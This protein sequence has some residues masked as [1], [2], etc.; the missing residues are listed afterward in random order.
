[1]RFSHL[2]I[3]KLVDLEKERFMAKGFHGFVWEVDLAS[4]KISRV[5]IPEEEY[6]KYF[7]GSG[8]AA[9]LLYQELD[10]EVDPLSERS[11][12]LVFPGLLT[13]HP[14]PTGCRTILAGRSPLTGIWGEATA[15][16]FWG[17]ELRSAGVDGLIIRGRAE[18]PTYLWITTEGVELRDATHLWGKDTFETHEIIRRETDQRARVTAIGIAGERLCRVAALIFEGPASR[19]AGRC[20][21]GALVGS[22]NLKA[23]AVRA[24]G[25]VPIHDSEGLRKLLKK[26]I[27]SIQ[28]FTAGLTKLGTPGAVEAVEAHGD[29]P[30]KNWRDGSWA[31]GA[32]ATC[33]QTNL[34]KYLDRHYACFSCPIRCSKIIRIE[35][36][37]YGSVHS[38][39][40]EYETVAGFGGN[41]L[42]DDFQLIAAANERCNRYGLDTISTSAAVAFAM[43]CYEKGLLSHQDTGGLDLKWGDPKAILGLVDWIA[44]GDGLGALL[45]QGTRRAAEQIGRNALEYVV[46]AKGLDLAFHD[47][48]AFTSMAANYATAV[49]G[50]CHLEGLTYFLGRGVPLEDMGYVEPP[51][52]HANEG[53]GKIAYDLQNYM[54]I[55]NP[56]GLCKF[57]FLGRVGPKMIAR[58]I[59]KVTGW[60]M[61]QTALLRTG[62]RIFNLKRMYNIRLGISRKDDMLPPR[63]MSHPR[64][65]GRAKG[66]LPHLGK[67]LNEY[68]E[69][70][71]WSEE[72]IPTPERL[73]GLGLKWTLE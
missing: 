65:D 16:G 17:A 19:A 5:D 68:Y 35:D 4:R 64:P 40:P 70:R 18:N 72:G 44:R 54:G 36:G 38:H 66:V 10:P 7:A 55:Y 14:V 58:W 47:P 12:L 60:T 52:P 30:I 62:E 37:L 61:D 49:R 59:E 13:G 56:L 48:R 32:T 42:N 31:Q 8:L 24:R 41:I 50:G 27:P 9:R 20:G 73:S 2:L 67:M 45:A 6:Q 29:L 71:G 1:M 3:L 57:I 46:D 26:D 43:E 51:D 23:L 33:A 15:G 69:L 11:P 63:M 53:K 39:Q 28:K 22:K 21:F 34:A 25:K